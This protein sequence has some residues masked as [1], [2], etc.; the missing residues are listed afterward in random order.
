MS[1]HGSF[2]HHLVVSVPQLWSP[3]EPQIDLLAYQYQCIQK[4]TN[5]TEAE[6][7]LPQMF[8]PR[9]YSLVFQHQR[10]R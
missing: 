2:E 3:Q 5:I 9:E 1:V 4:R 7:C 6:P 8:G 10:H